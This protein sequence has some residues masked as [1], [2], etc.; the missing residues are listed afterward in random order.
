MFC[1]NMFVLQIVGWHHVKTHV[2]ILACCTGLKNI[3]HGFKKN[4][5]SLL[6]KSGLMQLFSFLNKSILKSVSNFL[7][8]TDFLACFFTWKCLVSEN[9]CNTYMICTQKYCN[10][11]KL[12]QVRY[13]RR[14]ISMYLLNY[15]GESFSVLLIYSIITLLAKKKRKKGQHIQR[16]LYNLGHHESQKCDQTSGYFQLLSFF[17]SSVCPFIFGGTHSGVFRVLVD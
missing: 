10:L 16:C 4:S 8:P 9:F 17:Y 11:K 5:G 14:Y 13:P 12:F 1:S 2:I 7:K 6:K 3:N 15:M